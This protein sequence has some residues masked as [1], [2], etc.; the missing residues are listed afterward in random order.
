MALGSRPA[1]LILCKLVPDM[2]ALE[3]LPDDIIVEV[4]FADAVTMDGLV[5]LSLD[6]VQI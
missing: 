2:F 1:R 5:I 6:D 4:N 3:R